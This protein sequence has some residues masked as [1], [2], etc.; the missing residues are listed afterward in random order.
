MGVGKS[1]GAVTCALDYIEK[2]IDQTEQNSA[3]QKAA[4]Q[5]LEG[6]G[7]IQHNEKARED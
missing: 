1:V 5:F 4:I 3:G 6:S 2:L 7:G